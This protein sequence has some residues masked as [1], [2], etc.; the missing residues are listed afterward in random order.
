MHSLTVKIKRPDALSASETAAWVRI[1]E[2]NPAL[3]SP[4]FHPDYTQALGRLRNDAQVIIAYDGEKP[5]AFLP[6][7]GSG[8]FTAP[9]GAPMTDYHGF[10]C[11]PENE[12]HVDFEAVLKQ[13]G[14]GAFHFSAMV[15]SP[16]ARNHGLNTQEAAVIHMPEGGQAWRDLQ[17]SSYRRSL[18]SLRRRI[19]NSEADH[20]ERRFVYRSD[21]RALFDT[22]IEWKRKKFEETGKYDVLCA[23][24]TLPL[25]TQLW[26][27]GIN[28]DPNSSALRCDMH[29]LYFGD[30][31]AAIDLGLSDGSTFHSWIVAYD[32]DLSTHA[33]G[34]QL[35][36]G[37]I[38]ES[39]VLGYSRLDLGAGLEGYKRYYATENVHVHGGFV[40][41]RGPAAALSTLYGA[42]EKFGQKTMADIPGKL[43]RRY[44]QIAACDNTVSGRTR[45]MIEAVK[46]TRSAS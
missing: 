13:A 4:Y 46:T 7:Q 36:E 39:E 24:W 22:L 8:K 44:S 34:I 41:V 30:R 42:A 9:L 15:N 35:L 31:L 23:D 32:S 20:G 6:L 27:S 5:V 33:P 14:V 19:R 43:R 25:L 2:S 29:A 40:A 12:T 28:K 38:D 45:A 3:Y 21:D 26:E 18:K 16:L 10:I 37:V 1:R 17:D 11:A